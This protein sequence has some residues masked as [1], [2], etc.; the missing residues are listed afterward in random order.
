MAWDSSLYLR[1]AEERKQP[2]L[3]LLTRLEGNFNRILDLGCGPGN[4]TENLVEKYI[5][6]T[7]IGFDSDDNM[8]K[9]HARII[10]TLRL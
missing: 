10:R 1:F 9:K 6:S 8:L 3:D 7:V 5:T 2:C 4:S